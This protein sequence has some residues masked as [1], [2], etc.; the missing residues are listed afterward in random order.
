MIGP[1]VNPGKEGS[2]RRWSLPFP[3][4]LPGPWA[5][6]L[7]AGSIV[8]LAALLPL[9]STPDAYFLA[10]D[11]G[12]IQL[13][14]AKPALHF[15]TLFTTPWTEAIYGVRPDELRPL[16]ALS[17][18]I[19]SL[20][21]PANPF[22]YHLGSMALHLVN[23]LLVL[24]IARCL[25]GLGWSGATFAG[26]IFALMPVH[27]EVGAWISGR[28]DSIPAAC[29]LGSLLAFGLWRQRTAHR[30]GD[31][32]QGR[33]DRQGAPATPFRGPR[34]TWLLF[35]AA[36]ALFFGAL[37]SK[38]SAITMLATLVAYDVLVERRLPWASRQ[39]L[40]AYLPFALLTAAYLGLRLVLFGNAV[41]EQQVTP[42]TFVSFALIQATY[43]SMVATGAPV[44]RT[45]AIWVALALIGILA[46]LVAVVWALPAILQRRTGRWLGALACFGPIWWLITVAPLAVTYV[47]GRHLYLPSAGVAIVLGIA[48][49][50]LWDRRY[51]VGRTIAICGGAG[52]L[53]CY[54]LTLQEAVKE[55]NASAAHS[56][57]MAQDLW[58]VSAA[59]PGGS[60]V[61][62]NAPAANVGFPLWRDKA[63][64]AFLGDPGGEAAAG[65]G[66]AA[67][68]ASALPVAPTLIWA[69]AAPFV[70]GVPFAPTNLEARV[71]F[72]EPPGVY[73]CSA[74]QWLQRT[75]TTIAAWQ[76]QQERPTVIVLQWDDARKELLHRP[77][78]SGVQQQL[79]RILLAQSPDEVFELFQQVFV[80]A[81]GPDDESLAQR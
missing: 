10:D 7:L 80:H 73:C 19:D 57:Q 45:E 30:A 28:A 70:Y 52:L 74:E 40:L 33:G 78:A 15:L 24:A 54:G 4:L 12:L 68:A 22:G 44:L 49:A 3:F 71:A 48:F 67:D 62:V 23:T 20:W 26:L 56:H 14:S 76:A 32:S 61:I 72:I 53:L 51:R 5:P 11:F 29:Y 38:Q 46:A 47:S 41:R 64:F 27:A 66:S 42:D 77:G 35:L 17:Y 31:R 60:L 75:Q 63:V 9:L 65:D 43:L 69:W 55:W 79:D 34:V 37:F 81:F 39:T 25:V 36:I 16:V 50:T 21:G 1:V 2:I 18:Q 13:Y 59:A 6:P 58:R 8:A